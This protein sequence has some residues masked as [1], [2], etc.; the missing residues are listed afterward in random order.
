MVIGERLRALREERR[1]SRGEM[2][3]R[4]GLLRCYICRVENGYTVPAVETLGKFAN[5]LEVPIYRL[6]YEDTEPPKTGNGSER[7]WGPAAEDSEFF[8]QFQRYL[9]QMEAADRDVLLFMAQQMA[10]GSGPRSAKPSGRKR[11]AAR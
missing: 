10:N 6:F 8:R 3:K 5:A 7:G 4:T 2:E 11:P 1:I 9:S